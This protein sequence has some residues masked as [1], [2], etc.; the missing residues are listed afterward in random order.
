MIAGTLAV[1]DAPADEPLSSWIREAG[2][3][4][5]IQV[6]LTQSTHGDATPQAGTVAARIEDS[7]RQVLT[8]TDQTGDA[9]VDVERERVV[10]PIATGF[11]ADVT[12]AGLALAESIGE[13]DE[14]PFPFDVLSAQVGREFERRQIDIKQMYDVWSD[15]STVSSWMTGSDENGTT[16]AYHEAARATNPS[17][18]L[19]F[20]R[21]W[22]GTTMKGVVFRGGY[23]ALYTARHAGDGLQFVA[24]EIMP[25]TEPWDPEEHEDQTD[26][27]EFSG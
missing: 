11:A 19:G 10:V 21:S 6:E 3:F 1:L 18:G 15:E 14:F 8:G 7:Q 25:Y 20:V 5:A 17:I 13:D 16:M 24:D 9:Y 23:V 12:G 22:A 26:F 2:G 27:E 4:P